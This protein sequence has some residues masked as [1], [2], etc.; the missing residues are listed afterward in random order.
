MHR[1]TALFLVPALLAAAGCATTQGPERAERMGAL[2]GRT[3][4]SLVRELGVPDATTEAEGRRILRWSSATLEVVPEPYPWGPF[5]PWGYGYDRVGYAYGYGA[6]W[7]AP[8]TYRRWC[9]MELEFE[10]AEDAP[11]A[12]WRAVSW[13]T[14]GND[15]R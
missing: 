6:G 4:L 8:R 9:D 12:P 14:R 10:R 1:L 3:E 15:C 13:R 11:E 5:G 7:A 2:M